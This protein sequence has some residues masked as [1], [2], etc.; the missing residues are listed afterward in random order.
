MPGGKAGE[1]S[2]SLLDRRKKQSTRLVLTLVGSVKEKGRPTRKT[3]FT[4][5]SQEMSR[6][7]P[8]TKGLASGGLA[9]AG[10]KSS[11][12]FSS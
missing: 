11:G 7:S 5:S 6:A 12:K 10:G 2:P 8:K 4:K 1:D 9:L 3:G